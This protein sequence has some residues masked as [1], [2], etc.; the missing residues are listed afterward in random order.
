MKRVALFLVLVLMVACA[1]QKPIAVDEQTRGAIKQLTDA[2]RQQPTNMPWIYVLATYHDRAGETGE[3]VKWLARLDELGWQHG[4]SP[5]AFKNSR[6]SAFRNAVARLDAREPKV[7]N[8]K[9]AFTLKNQRDLVPEGIAYD[10]VDDVF[11]VSGIYRRKVLRVTRDGRATDFVKEAQDGMLGGLG[12]KIDPAKRRLWV[13]SSTTDEMKGYVKGQESS[14]LAAYDL[15]DGSLVKKLDPAPARLNDLTILADGTIFAT[16]MGGHTVVRLA[17]GADAFEQYADGFLFPNGIT[18]D[19]THLYVSD[20]R[21]LHRFVLGDKT[22]TKIEVPGQLAGGND[23]L[24]FHQGTLI[25]IQN[26]YG[27]PRVIRIHLDPPRVEVL[28]SKNE[29]FELPTTGA[30]AG[31]EYFFI[32][33]PGL[34]SFD[35]DGKIWPMER[36]EEPVMLRIDLG[37]RRLAAAFE[38]PA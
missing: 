18:N 35:D 36:L 2:L 13:I 27:N 17:P 38:P 24:D 30:I 11:Y 33:N 19:G 6:G 16:D 22:R 29:L 28:E 21:G 10:P 7:N 25:G 5:L 26:S 9:V 37:V 23:G 15:R 3:V 34:R 20:F 32:A 31:G 12:M 1:T 4:V 14:M 8:A